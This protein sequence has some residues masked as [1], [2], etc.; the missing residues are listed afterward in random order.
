MPDRRDKLLARARRNPTGLRFSELVSL[1][2]ACGFTRR[3]IVGDHFVHGRDDVQEIINIQ[4]EGGRAKAYRVR[5]FVKLI[6]R[7]GLP[8][9]EDEQA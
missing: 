6:G 8:S 2:E 1:I 5:Q 3:R 9:E 4:P 7:Y